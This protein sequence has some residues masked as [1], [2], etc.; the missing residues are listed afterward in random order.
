MLSRLFSKRALTGLANAD[1]IRAAPVEIR[2][3][4]KVDPSFDVKK[5]AKFL[6]HDNHKNRKNMRKYLSS[7]DL[8]PR[9]AISLNEE[10]ELSLKRLQ[11]FCD[12]KLI[13]VLDFKNNP[14]NIFAAHEIMSIIDPATA[15]KMTVQFNLFGGTVFKL[16]TEKHHSVFLEGIDNLNDIGCFG[17][18][19]LGFGNNAVEMQTTATL[20]KATDEW[21]IDTPTNL[22]Q[23]Y[24]ITNGALHAKHIVV[25][26]QL[27]ID[28]ENHGI[29]GVLV[30][31]RD[32]N[33]KTCE[34]VTIE[35][36]GHRMGLNG[37]DNA[38]ISFD[39]VRVPRAN[40]LDAHSQVDKDG[41]FVS[42]I[43]KKRDRFLKV[44]D[45]LL[46]G[47]ICIASMSMGGT[48]A[49]LAIAVK[50]AQSRLT[51]GPTG[52]SDTPIIA[53][54]LQ[55]NALMP[56]L[57]RSITLNVGLDKVKRAWAGIGGYFF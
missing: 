23:K 36:M 10:R 38:K 40:L 9:Y 56:L 6:D 20:D 50:Y 49:S 5:M 45:Q 30:R 31:M 17:L 26:A 53:Y 39:K 1:K 14:L 7:K 46:S 43:T 12:A 13:S 24:W 2:E 51:V 22:A 28:G 19:E 27:M 11:A 55:K 52:K 37:V 34:G 3:Q 48:K 29:H 15:V 25:F 41:N 33:M 18:T 54:Q 32:E 35:D 42:G 47:R 4:T 57:A 8:T 21:V 16:G 44:A